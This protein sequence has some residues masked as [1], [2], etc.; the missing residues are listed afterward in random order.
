MEQLVEQ[1]VA[2]SPPDDNIGE[3]YVGESVE[4]TPE[5]G[6]EGESGEGNRVDQ[7]TTREETPGRKRE[8]LI[9]LAHE[10]YGV[11][12]D[13]IIVDKN[14]EVKVVMT[15]NGK[16]RLVDPR[17]DLVKGFNLNQAGYEKLNE[18][19]QL[20]KQVQAFFD[21]TKNNP[22]KLWEM[23]DRLGIDKYDLAKS[24]LQEKIEESEMTDEQRRLR[25]LERKEAEWK[26]KEEEAAKQQEQMALQQETEKEMKRFDYEF[27]EAMKD[28]GFQKAPKGTKSHILMGAIG[29]MMVA[30]QT[31]RELSAKD[32]VHR[33]ALK[34]Q[35]YV[36]GV[37]DDID[38]DHIIKIVPDR[39]VK[40]IRSADLKRLGTSIPTSR[41]NSE[42]GHEVPLQLVEDDEPKRPR[43]K[44]SLSSFFDSL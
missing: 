24:L 39:I 21:E 44:Q 26:A 43:K 5:V 9:E 27:T 13:K 34:W 41:A 25:D 4:G 6:N 11:D 20:Q 42:L 19:K 33:A 17:K 15:I 12:K 37:F 18:G 16:K 36:H 10:F 31:G 35:E 32:A 3:A 23:A 14:N 38:D 22:R 2:E 7:G 1:P 30:N 29:E 8:E 40:A 28:Y